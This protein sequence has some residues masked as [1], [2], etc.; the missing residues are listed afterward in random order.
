M[1]ERAGGFCYA[2]ATQVATR[3]RFIQWRTQHD[4]L[5]LLETSLDANLLDNHVRYRFADSPV[6]FVAVHETANRQQVV[7]LV[8]TVNSIHRLG[9]TH[10]EQLN[11]GRRTGAT[12]A[13]SSVSLSV[14]HEASMQAT[15]DPSTFHVIGHIGGGTCFVGAPQEM[16][17][18]VY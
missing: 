12:S 4:C 1:A 6:L 16:G 8:V 14:F 3:N 7:L 5:E 9:F 11:G 15:R 10:P 17:A 13:E 18:R 2:D